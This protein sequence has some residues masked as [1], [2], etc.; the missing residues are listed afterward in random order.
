MPRLFI[1]ID[2]AE[3]VAAKLQDIAFGLP[4]AAWVPA[5]QYHL[6]LRFLGET[7]EHVLENIVHALREVRAESFHLELKGVGHFPLR[8]NPEVLWVGV[9]SNDSLSRLNRKLEASLGR[10]GVGPE[11]RK[12]H[13]H[14]TLARLK[15]G[16]G[17]H[18]GDFEVLHSLFKIPGVPVE[19]FHLYSSRLTPEGAIHTVE[20][21][22]GLE[23][24]LEGLDGEE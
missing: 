9:S 16:A 23:G 19:R 2:F 1:A 18:A 20:A 6:T 3:N 4:G 7:P 21:S 22:Y 8:G 15:N 11:G 13:P 14:V 10:A 17:R 12:F 5:H 24:M